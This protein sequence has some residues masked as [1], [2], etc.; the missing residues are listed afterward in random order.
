MGFLEMTT[1]QNRPRGQDR[2]R[3]WRQ[4]NKP[5]AIFYVCYPSL[6]SNSKPTLVKERVLILRM[7]LSTENG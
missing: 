7:S 1:G 2:K 5:N 3:L 6:L 4:D